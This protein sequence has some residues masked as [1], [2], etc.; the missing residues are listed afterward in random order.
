MSETLRPHVQSTS[1]RARPKV[2]SKLMAVSE[3]P[4]VAFWACEAGRLAQFRG[5]PRP[6]KSTREKDAHAGPP[7][8]PADA[9]PRS[10][11]AWAAPGGQEPPAG[12][13]RGPRGP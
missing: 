10:L 5:P 13:G 2:R 8:L 11:P 7:A 3:A 12:G 1:T 9:P 6:A 4:A